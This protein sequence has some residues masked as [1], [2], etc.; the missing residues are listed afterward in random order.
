[1]TGLEKEEMALRRWGAGWWV[2]REMFY[3]DVTRSLISSV[4]DR[5]RDKVVL[6]MV[7]TIIEDYEYF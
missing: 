3:E 1:M 2:M 5:M 6:D 7:R 4:T